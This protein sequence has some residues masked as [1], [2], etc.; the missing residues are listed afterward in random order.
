[1]PASAAGYFIFTAAILIG[2]LLIATLRRRKA[3]AKA[4]RIATVEAAAQTVAAAVRASQ[5]RQARRERFNREVRQ[6]VIE[7]QSR[8]R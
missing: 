8:R 3:I 4:T 2:W 7:I 6:R 1:M 5:R